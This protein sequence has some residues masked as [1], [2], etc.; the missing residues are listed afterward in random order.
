MDTGVKTEK[1]LTV[2]VHHQ[3]LDPRTFKVPVKWIYRSSIMAWML[4]AIS[5]TSVFFA[6]KTY[7]MKGGNQSGIIQDLEK[8]LIDLKRVNE[9]L[10]SRP[11]T[12]TTSTSS[13]PTTASK[14]DDPNSRDTKPEAE[15]GQVM[16]VQEG[17]WTG[18]APHI[19][20]PPA[21]VTSPIQLSD[22]KINWQG[23]FANIT[24]VVAYREQGKGSQQGHLVVLA[25]GKDR[26]FAH[27]D[28]VLNVPS[29]S[30]L[31]DAERGEYFSV[32]RFRFL[33][34]K[35]GPFESPSQLGQIQIYLFNLEN[36]LILTQSFQY[37]KK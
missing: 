15:I 12:S 8:E 19:S 10:A 7:R 11:L 28:N 22:V 5:L 33:K 9:N 13:T 37:G 16:D 32:A 14:S 29:S 25:R 26:I 34:T 27:P 2:Q 36:K 3:N 4:I 31:F 18:L 6:V 35:L 1:V 23:K 20:L 24:G 21:G 17:I 30:F